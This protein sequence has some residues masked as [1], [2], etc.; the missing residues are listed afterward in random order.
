MTGD[1]V[2]LDALGPSGEYPT[3]KREL[4]CD[5]GGVPVA[6]MSLVPR[7]FVTR[8]INAQRAARPLPFADREAALA[9]AAEIFVTSSIAGLGFDD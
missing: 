8:S 9:H 3:R 6:A 1:L 4:I 2:A 5:T 7:L